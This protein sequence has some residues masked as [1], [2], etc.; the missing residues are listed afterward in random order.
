MESRIVT[1]EMFHITWKILFQ[2]FA[3]GHDTRDHRS[4]ID[5]K[6]VK[7]ITATD[8]HSETTYSPK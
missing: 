2:L 6:E 3:I 5:L 4:T 1:K 7:K 8:R